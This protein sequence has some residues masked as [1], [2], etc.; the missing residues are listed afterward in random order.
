MPLILPQLSDNKD[1]KDVSTK[2]DEN[3]KNDD[4]NNSKDNDNNEEEDDNTLTVSFHTRDLHDARSLASTA[5]Y[6]HSV[7][8]WD[9]TQRRLV[10]NRTFRDYLSVPS[11]GLVS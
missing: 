10:K 9:I 11:S 1:E 2:D 7:I 6:L 3:N 4:E 8:F 5:V